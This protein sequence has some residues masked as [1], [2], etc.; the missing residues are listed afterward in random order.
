[1]GIEYRDDST[2]SGGRILITTKH[3]GLANSYGSMRI[4]DAGITIAHK[5]NSQ[6]TLD[7][8]TTNI[9]I[10]P[11]I[12]IGPNEDVIITATTTKG[13]YATLA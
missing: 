1:M 13:I 8:G 9:K 12:T 3:L 7:G 11:G 5:G 10:S 6:I 2:G 4:D